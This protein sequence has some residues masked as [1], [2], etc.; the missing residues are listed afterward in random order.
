MMKAILDMTTHA[1]DPPIASASRQSHAGARELERYLV[2]L[3]RALFAAIFIVAAIGHFSSKEIAYAAQ[4]GVPMASLLVPLS[5]VLALA[6][7]L[8]VLLGYKAKLGAW[9]LIVFLVPVTVT[10]H[11]FWAATDPAMA[12]MQQVHFM[13]NVA[14]IGAALLITHFGAGPVSIDSRR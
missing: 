13:K 12:Q 8:S 9:M 10:M 6:G 2:P 14:M 11:A 3:G 1:F 7:G 5:G 4:A